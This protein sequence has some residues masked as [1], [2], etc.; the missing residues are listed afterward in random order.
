MSA[1]IKK[2]YY[3]LVEPDLKKGYTLV[4]GFIFHTEKIYDEDTFNRLLTFC[5]EYHTLTGQRALC[6][7]MPPVS[8]RVKDEM[9]RAAATEIKFVENLKTLQIVADLGFHGHFWQSMQ[10]S[11]ESIDNQIRNSTYQPA[12]DGLIKEQFKDQITWVQRTPVAITKTYAAGWWFTHRIIMQQQL[13]NDLEYDFSFSRIPWSSGTWGKSVMQ[14]HQVAFGEPFAVELPEGKITCVQTVMG[15]PNTPYPQD[16][17]RIV[18]SLLEPANKTVLGMVT[19]HDYDLAGDNLKF[20]LELIRHL[21]AKKYIQFFSI[22][23]LP[24]ALRER[25]LKNISI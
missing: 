19:T 18:N 21:K 25:K 23:D 15:T 2:L 11:F 12:H 20:A 14:K 4:L 16:F 17:I 22:D 10:H 6:T 13:L 3:T 9:Q 8:F 5:K 7:I 24:V 1:F